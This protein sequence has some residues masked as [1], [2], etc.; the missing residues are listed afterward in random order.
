MY[1]AFKVNL[2]CSKYQYLILFMTNIPLYGYTAFC[3][4]ICQLM[5]VWVSYT[6]CLLWI[7]VLW[8]FVYIFIYIYITYIS[9]SLRCIPR[10]GVAASYGYL[11]FHCLKNCR[12]FPKW[13]HNFIFPSIVY[14]YSYFST[15]SL[16]LVI[17]CL[18]YSHLGGYEIILN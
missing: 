14:K 17:I 12:F 13:L 4:D 16:T 1:N 3:L 6:F 10:N 15:S 11:M 5:D 8:T 9:M 2:Y 18:L 7:M